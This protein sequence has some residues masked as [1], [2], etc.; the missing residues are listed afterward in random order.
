MSPSVIVPAPPQPPTVREALRLASRG[1][2]AG[3]N[4][5]SRDHMAECYR[6]QRSAIRESR[7]GVQVVER[8]LTSYGYDEGG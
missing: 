3:C 1:L 4:G 8:M 5:T 2:C 6:R 7:D